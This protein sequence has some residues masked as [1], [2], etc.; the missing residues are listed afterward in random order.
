MHCVFEFPQEGLAHAGKVVSSTAFS[1]SLC[2]H[3][4]IEHSCQLNGI[5]DP[6]D[7]KPS[8]GAP[9]HFTVARFAW[10][11]DIS[12]DDRVSHVVLWALHVM[13]SRLVSQCLHQLQKV[14]FQIL[15]TSMFKALHSML[16]DFA[17]PSKVFAEQLQRII[18]VHLAPLSKK[19]DGML[20]FLEVTPVHCMQKLRKGRW[21]F[22]QAPSE[23]EQQVLFLGA[24]LTSRS[25]DE[26]VKTTQFLSIWPRVPV[27]TCTPQ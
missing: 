23:M 7:E 3:I 17:N 8:Q 15:V 2:R 9:L 26:F 5:D 14:K 4:P 19:L 18:N 1:I 27:L 12:N 11:L 22:S 13:R 20:A 6:S 16:P 10:T 21:L 25:S 24:K